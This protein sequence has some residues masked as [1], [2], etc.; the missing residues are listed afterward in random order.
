MEKKFRDC[1]KAPTKK[2]KRLV[3]VDFY[4]KKKNFEKN[5]IKAHKR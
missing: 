1:L 4:T 3:W 2:C 5:Y